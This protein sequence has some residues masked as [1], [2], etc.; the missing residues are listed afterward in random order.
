MNAPALSILGLA[1]FLSDCVTVSRL[2]YQSR[3]EAM[4]LKL[5]L[6]L[7]LLL[8]S[9]FTL[10]RQLLLVLCAPHRD[11][12]VFSRLISKRQSFASN[13]PELLH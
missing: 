5:A 6:I 9:A 2:Y 10:V 7:F 13:L 8:V 11:A 1:V 12:C 4:E 3:S